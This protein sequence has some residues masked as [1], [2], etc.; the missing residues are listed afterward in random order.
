MQKVT[1]KPGTL[2]ALHLP[3]LSGCT[4]QVGVQFY[5]LISGYAGFIRRSGFTQPEMYVILDTPFD[6]TTLNRQ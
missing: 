5:R 6:F 3:V 1:L 4:A 2:A